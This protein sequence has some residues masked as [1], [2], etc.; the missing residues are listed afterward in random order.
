M[1]L[2]GDTMSMNHLMIQMSKNVLLGDITE[3]IQGRDSF[4]AIIGVMGF[5]LFQTLA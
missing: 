3:F 1:S 5:S 2:C 4:L